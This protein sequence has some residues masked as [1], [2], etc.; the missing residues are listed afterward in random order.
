[1]RLFYLTSLY[2]KDAKYIRAT[3][4]SQTDTQCH[5]ERGRFMADEGLLFPVSATLALT[6]QFH[7]TSLWN[8][9]QDER[10]VIGG[11]AVAPCF[12]S[13]QNLTLHFWQRQLRSLSDVF[14]KTFDAPHI[15][16][17]VETFGEAVGVNHHAIARFHGNLHRRFV[18]HGVI[19]QTENRAARF[20]QPR[21]LARLN[22]HRRRMP[23]AGKFETAILV[24]QPCCYHG[25]VEHR[26]A[27]I[28]FHEAVE[29]LHHRA[30]PGAALYLRH[31]LRIY[32]VGNQ[33]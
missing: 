23:G 3:P 4:H 31:R 17:L 33:R 18:V 10:H 21:R 30:E 27:E 12:D 26:A 11:R 19:E 14:A 22:D 28:P 32:A 24:I 6:E 1:M 15:A 16:V 13:I 8:F 2:N 5:P 9:N 25:E 7:G 20:K 29:V